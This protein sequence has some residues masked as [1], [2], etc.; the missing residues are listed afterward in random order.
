MSYHTFNMLWQHSL[1]FC[2]LL[3]TQL[4]SVKSIG[5]FVTDLHAVVLW[6]N[7]TG[8]E[9][10]QMPRKVQKCICTPFL[11]CIFLEVNIEI[12]FLSS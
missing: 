12:L 3:A 2:Y 6:T 7:F 5:V 11:C 4:S 1:K 10:Q 9:P 8:S